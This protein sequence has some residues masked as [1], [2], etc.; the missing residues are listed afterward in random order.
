MGSPPHMRGKDTLDVRIRDCLGITPA[1][2][3]KRLHWLPEQQL[4]WDHPRTCGEKSLWAD[5]CTAVKGSPPHMRGKGIRLYDLLDAF[6]ITPAH[7]GKSPFIRLWQFAIRD[8]PRTCGEK[9]GQFRSLCA[10]MGSPPHMRGKAA[11]YNDKPDSSGI[12]P[13]HAGKRS[14]IGNT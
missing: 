4:L 8:H 11:I 10:S 9:Q 7:A 3:G 14:T 12:T 6:G 5:K 1:H 13:A 2:A